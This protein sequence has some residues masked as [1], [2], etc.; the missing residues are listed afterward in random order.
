MPIDQSRTYR[1][2]VQTMYD[3]GTSLPN[4]AIEFSFA[5]VA[6]EDPQNP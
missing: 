2:Y 3:P 6:N 5:G 1:Y 4:P